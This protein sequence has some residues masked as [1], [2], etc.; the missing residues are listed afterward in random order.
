MTKTIR[1]GL[2]LIA[3]LAF[4][5][6]ASSAQSAGEATYKAKCQNCHG[7][8]GMADTSIARAL[9][10]KPVSDPTVKKLSEA[11][12]IAATK[13]GMGKMQPYKDKLTDVQ[14]KDSVDYFRSLIK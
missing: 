14:I 9:K 7:S 6:T 11:E 13:N 12:M 1:F 2:V 4:A 3:G 5:A 8:A 10:V